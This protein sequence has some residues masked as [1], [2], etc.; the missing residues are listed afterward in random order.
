[1]NAATHPVTIT[2]LH[3][4]GGANR[5]YAMLGAQ[6]GL[7]ESKRAVHVRIKARGARANLVRITHDHA[8]DTYEIQAY[9]AR[10]LSMAAAGRASGVYMTELVRTCESLTGLAWKI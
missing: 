6:V 9:R 4:L 1:M 7:D 3:Q 2:T 8:T 10:G 5:L